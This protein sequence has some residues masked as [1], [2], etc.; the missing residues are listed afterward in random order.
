MPPTRYVLG[1]TISHKCVCEEVSDATREFRTL[2]QIPYS[3]IWEK[4]K[5]RRHREGR[6]KNNEKKSTK[7]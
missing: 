6:T 1:P 3:W 5:R 7:T 4:G 2:L